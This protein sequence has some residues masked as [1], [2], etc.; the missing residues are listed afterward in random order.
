MRLVPPT[1]VVQKSVSEAAFSRD[2]L[3]TF[4]AGN[5]VAKVCCICDRFILF[6]EEQFCSFDQL[7][8]DK[9]KEALGKKRITGL[10]ATAVRAI[11]NHYRP[12]CVSPRSSEYRKIRDL[13]LS[14]RSYRVQ[15]SQYEGLGCCKECKKSLDGLAKQKKNPVEPPRFAIANGLPFSFGMSVFSVP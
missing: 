8:K 2:N 6:G 4:E 12:N 11:H 5:H 14:P 13:Y 10:K 7:A 1:H 15:I 9:T 3:T